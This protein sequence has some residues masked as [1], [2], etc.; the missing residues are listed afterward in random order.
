M[1]IVFS[2]WSQPF[3]VCH[4]VVFRFP[5]FFLSTVYCLNF[6]GCVWIFSDV[7]CTLSMSRFPADVFIFS[8]NFIL[9]FFVSRYIQVCVLSCVL[10]VALHTVCACVCMCVCVL[11]KWPRICT[12]MWGGAVVRNQ[13][14]R[15]D[16][17]EKEA[18]RKRKEEKWRPV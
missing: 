11:P 12:G 6:V 17:I 3:F 1:Q 18:K 2:S 15:R 10:C 5:Q 13:L 9:F 8:S 7:R 4:V 14:E 16:Q